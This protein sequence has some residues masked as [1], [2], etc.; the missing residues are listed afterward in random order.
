MTLTLRAI[1]NPYGGPKDL[2]A[3]R[4]WVKACQHVC[5]HVLTSPEAEAWAVRLVLE[6][7]F[8]SERR[9][10][11]LARQAWRCEGDDLQPIYDAYVVAIE[12]AVHRG[13]WVQQGRQRKHLSANA[14]AAVTSR[15]TVCSG[16][17]PAIG[18]ALGTSAQQAA[19][20]KQPRETIVEL[21]QRQPLPRQTSPAPEAASPGGRKRS[22]GSKGSR[23]EAL[24]RRREAAAQVAA[25]APVNEGEPL[26]RYLRFLAAAKWLRHDALHVTR[27]ESPAGDEASGDDDLNLVRH[28]FDEWRRRVG[29]GA[30]L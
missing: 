21:R 14:V 28:S 20:D 8:P 19:E 10:L 30:D 26:Q 22:K 17:I 24:R 4:D 12:E 2:P 5:D 25:E 13:W 18:S 7:D 1:P 9:R 16:L 11:H 27:S 23:R 6:G 29:L 15:S 3:W